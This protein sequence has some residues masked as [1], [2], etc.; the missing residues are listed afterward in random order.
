MATPQI[1]SM[2]DTA[3][4][5]M[6]GLLSQA[7]AS[8]T[9]LRIGVK[10]RGCSG[11]QYFMEYATASHNADEQVNKDG[12]TLYIDPASVMHLLGTEIDYVESDTEEGFVFRNPNE[13]G[14]CG[15]GESFH[16]SN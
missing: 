7:D 1:I 16:T 4:T 3:T 6:K 15:C 12:V 14:R 13:K 8:V 2:T 5:H 11:L 10:A 9:G